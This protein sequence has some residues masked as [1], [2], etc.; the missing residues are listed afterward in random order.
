[1]RYFTSLGYGPSGAR[2]G[3]LVV[4]EPSDPV[5]SLSHRRVLLVDDDVASLETWALLLADAGVQ[6]EVAPDAEAC[7]R[8]AGERA[9]DLIVV[10]FRLGDDSGLDVMR[11]LRA[12]GSAVPFILATA[13]A[14][15]AVTA[16]TSATP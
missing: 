12:R 16:R 14:S 10:D 7:L 5:S 15:V 3:S 4:C 6:V 13:H 2:S 1:M 8:V 9:F 11:R